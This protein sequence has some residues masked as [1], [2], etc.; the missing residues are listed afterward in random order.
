MDHYGGGSWTMISNVQNHGVGGGASS[1]PSTPSSSNPHHHHHHQQHDLYTIQQQAPPQQQFYQQR[2]QQQQQPPHQSLSSH[3]HL[4]Q[5]VENLAEVTENGSRDQHSDA[6]VAELTSQF[7]KCQQL[8]NSMSGSINSRSMTL[9]G[10]KCQ[11]E[12]CD[13]LSKQRRDLI[14]K[15]RS[16]VEKLI[17]PEL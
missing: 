7:D 8:L 4:S 3:F 2:V 16:S 14:S 1:N 12:E 11:M 9:E 15:Y 10:Q 17:N 13:H 5:L 6:L